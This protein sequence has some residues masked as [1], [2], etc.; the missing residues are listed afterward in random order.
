[1]LT[2]QTYF[3]KVFWM[4][5]DLNDE[6][7]NGTP[8]ILNFSNGVLSWDKVLKIGGKLEGDYATHLKSWIKRPI[9]WN[10]I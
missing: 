10:S 4:K 8:K 7:F 1:M 6:L 2:C 9:T 3:N 5:D